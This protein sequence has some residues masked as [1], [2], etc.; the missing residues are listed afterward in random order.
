MYS[1]LTRRYL[2][3]VSLPVH[4]GYRRRSQSVSSAISSL[5][6]KQGRVKNGGQKKC[7]T[8]YTGKT[9]KLTCQLLEKCKGIITESRQSDIALQWGRDTPHDNEVSLE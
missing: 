9:N 8:I 4:F 5:G 7:L 6:L 1:L 3:V 2:R